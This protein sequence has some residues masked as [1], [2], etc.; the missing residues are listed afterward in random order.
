MH[1]INARD[2]AEQRRRLTPDV[3]NAIVRD[4]VTTMYAVVPKPNK[5]CCTKVVKQLTDKYS[6]MRDVGTNVTGYVSTCYY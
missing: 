5:E 3:R 6:F 1:A 4:L 2:E